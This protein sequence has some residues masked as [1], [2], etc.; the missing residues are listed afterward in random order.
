MV[1]NR[2]EGGPCE[3]RQKAT[4]AVA[5]VSMESRTRQREVSYTA[6]EI[7]RQ[8]V[9]GAAWFLLVAYGKTYEE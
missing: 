3:A 8:S 7:A 9:G 5:A 4:Q 2:R 6:K 1:A